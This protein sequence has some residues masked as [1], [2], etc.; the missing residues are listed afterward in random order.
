[1]VKRLKNLQAGLTPKRRQN[2]RIPQNPRKTH[3]AI[4]LARLWHY[5]PPCGSSAS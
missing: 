5:F 4:H 2:P 3:P 1:M